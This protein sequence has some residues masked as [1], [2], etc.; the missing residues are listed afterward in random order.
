ML[1]HTR[2]N[3]PCTLESLGVSDTC[4]P[5]HQLRKS[6]DSGSSSSASKL[7]SEAPGF[8]S[9]NKM[10]SMKRSSEFCLLNGLGDEASDV[11]T[12]EFVSLVVLLDSL[13]G[14]LFPRLLSVE[15]S[16]SID[17]LS[18]KSWTELADGEFL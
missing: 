11:W 2:G 12:F 3:S 14:D 15:E 13:L 18:G 5:V 7:C 4:G 9:D 8:V 10:S 17:L 16:V 1:L 6:S